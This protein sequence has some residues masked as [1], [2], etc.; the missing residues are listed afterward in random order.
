[1][2]NITKCFTQIDIEKMRWKINR[3]FDFIYYY[4]KCD[5][6]LLNEESLVIKR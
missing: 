4:C 1:M 6:I 5:K 3:Y 2:K